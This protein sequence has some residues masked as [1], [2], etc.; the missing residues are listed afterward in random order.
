VNQ[1]EAFSCVKI[2]AQFKDVGWKLTDG[3]SAR[4]E[5]L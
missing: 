5:Y 2:D 4:Y 1:G 3:P